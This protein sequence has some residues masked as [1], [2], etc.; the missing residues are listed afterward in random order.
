MKRSSLARWIILGVSVGSL[1]LPA[2]AQAFWPRR[3][4]LQPFAA[5]AAEPAPTMEPRVGPAPSY[6][7]TFYRLNSRY[8]K[9]YGGFHSSYFDQMGIPTGDLGPRGNGIIMTPW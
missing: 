2:S 7:E 5:A 6:A 4:F 1:V 3:A 9:F 8:P